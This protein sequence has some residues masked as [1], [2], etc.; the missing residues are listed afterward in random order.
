MRLLLIYRRG[1]TRAG[2]KQLP[3][4]LTAVVAFPF[5]ASIIVRTTTAPQYVHPGIVRRRQNKT[6]S[7]TRERRE[8]AP[9]MHAPAAAELGA[10]FST[11]LAPPRAWS[12]SATF[13]ALES[14]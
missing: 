5:R 4:Y 2:E 3:H 13:S 7:V 12:A 14:M 10:V 1:H 6:V 8:N 9:S 11:I